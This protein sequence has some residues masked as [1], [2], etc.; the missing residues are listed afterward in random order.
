VKIT[1]YKELQRPKKNAR[2][3]EKAGK[4]IS[5][6]KRNQSPKKKCQRAL[7]ETRKKEGNQKGITSKDET[8]ETG[9]T[10]KSKGSK[11]AC[12]KKGWDSR[13]ERPKGPGSEL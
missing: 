8:L 12:R 7:P 10:D 11:K 9:K 3:D 2:E 4:H 1:G 6:L 13:T 5:G